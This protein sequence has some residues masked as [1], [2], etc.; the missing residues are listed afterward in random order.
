MWS[1]LAARA[2]RQRS[3]GCS[4]RLAHTVAN[5]RKSK[6]SRALFVAGGLGAG[7]LLLQPAYAD[8]LERGDASLDLASRGSK[9]AKPP[10]PS[11]EKNVL[12]TFTWGTNKYHTTSSSDLYDS[13]RPT[14]FA[15]LSGAGVALRD[16]AF[17]EKHAACVDAAGNVYQWGD[18]FFGKG[19]PE[20]KRQPIP[21]LKGKDIVKLAMSA[22][23]IYALSSSGKVY[24]IS[25]DIGKQAV[26]A[27]TPGV[28]MSWW[29][30]ARLWQ[31]QPSVDFIELHPGSK[32]ASNERFASL[33]AG[34]S[35]LLAVTS[36]GR[37]FSTPISSSAN[38]HGQLGVRQVQLL[39]PRA[40][41]D[42]STSAP[43]RSSVDLIPKALL[44]PYAKSTPGIR[45]P[46]RSS[47]ASQASDANPTEADIR[48]CDMLFE[49][50]S[51]RGVEIAQV[52]A[53]DRSSYAR[54]KKE[55][56]VLGWGANEYGQLALGSTVTM[57]CVTVPTEIVFTRS[58]QGAPGLRCLDITAGG[59]VVYFTVESTRASTASDSS[60]NVSIDL[61]AAGMG[62][63]GSL[64][65]ASWSQ[66]QGSPV[67]VKGVSGIQEYNEA[68]RSLQPLAPKLVTASPTHH[69][70]IVMDTSTSGGS[71]SGKSAAQPA[72]GCDIMTW[73]S[74]ADYQLG[75]GKRSNMP[76][77]THLPSD[78]FA[79]GYDVDAKVE[80]MMT[81]GRQVDAL[82]D[83][84]GK[85]LAKNARV[86][87]TVV[88]GWGCGAVYWKVV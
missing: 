33:S 67:R 27:D 20:D 50:P 11:G 63:F 86:E 70:M 78:P 47:Q 64:G 71:A 2:L 49:I 7:A 42:T 43:V 74:N 39:I 53:G 54:T 84:E 16:L 45:T 6:I 25:S 22:S 51:L 81:R 38:S 1:Q 83:L 9:Y 76:Q 23:K 59:D 34:R 55:G 28:R 36:T 5:G 52:S 15:Q 46:D 26:N 85:T 48:F 40:S 73:G 12:E 79:G 58:Y 56:R 17:H 61:F 41:Q 37:T 82:R 57:E 88:A 77:P 13:R 60:P 72:Q 19:H 62:Q 4:I 10:T 69:A 44:D 8:I 87:Q 31:T 3:R 29:N 24:V 30:P 68:T 80:R 18:G 32:L 35:H 14:P 66:A 65:N 75:I 21:T